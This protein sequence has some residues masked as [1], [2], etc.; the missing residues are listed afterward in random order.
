MW[1]LFGMH[2]PNVMSYYERYA[3][4]VNLK[5]SFLVWAVFSVL[6]RKK[7]T[8]QKRRSLSNSRHVI[9]MVKANQFHI[10]IKQPKEKQRER[11]FWFL[12]LRDISHIKTYLHIEM[13]MEM[14]KFNLTDD[15]NRQITN[16]QVV[17]VYIND[18]VYKCAWIKYE[19][20]M[21]LSSSSFKYKTN[22]T[23]KCHT[24]Q[25]HSS[26]IR[27][28]SIDCIDVRTYVFCFLSRSNRKFN[29]KMQLSRS[30]VSIF[31]EVSQKG[32]THTHTS[33]TV[34]SST[35]LLIW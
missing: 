26:K 22:W 11:N 14:I 29:L 21:V 7:K 28:D 9:T 19:S 1:I 23:E 20:W 18:M 27:I 5:S 17:S 8:K 16:H 15:W 13:E 6:L 31:E 3:L 33:N 2:G 25:Y 32:H 12:T 30:C 10:L 4:A 35:V 24:Q 34:L